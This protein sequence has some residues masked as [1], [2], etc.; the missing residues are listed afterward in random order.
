[1]IDIH[2]KIEFFNEWHTGS[3]LS[4]GAD[5]D[6]LV[7]K[8]KDNLPF[9]PG[10]TIKGLLRQ[11]VEEILEFKGEYDNKRDDLVNTFGLLSEK[12]TLPEDDDADTEIEEL[13]KGKCFAPMLL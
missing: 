3:G 11:A 12:K 7:I 13:K 4:A 10:K 8:D 6:D 5:V 2:Y 1:M 9:V